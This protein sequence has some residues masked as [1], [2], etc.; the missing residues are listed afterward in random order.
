MSNTK[1]SF[2]N[3]YS[4]L[5]HPQVLAKLASIESTQFD[6][7]GLDVYSLKA[8]EL[9]KMKINA[10]HAKVYLVSGGTQANLIVISSVLRP[11]EAVISCETGHIFTHE[12]GAIEATGHKICAV[13]GENAKL[14]SKDIK[15]VLNEHQNEHMVKPKLVYLSLSTELGSVYTKNEL[16]E[17][18]ECCREN[19]LYLHIDGARLGAGINS[20]ACDLSYSDIAHFSDTFFMGGT[21][22]GILF[23][24][25]IVI[26]NEKLQEDFRY[27]IK[28]KGGLLSKGASLGLQFLALLE[29]ESS[30]ADDLYDE[31]AKKANAMAM[32]LANGIR[33]LGY[34]FFSE[35]ETNQIFPIFPCSTINLLREY[36]DFH[37]WADISEGY[38][39]IRLVVSWATSLETI[40]K[41]LSDLSHT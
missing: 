20:P 29:K 26:C 39:A 7:Y 25:A 21:K 12:T 9:I 41:F 2:K 10:P 27:T 13:K 37:D 38:K 15:N 31:L 6:G 3:D 35:P 1:I 28:Q 4:E 8:E 24:E 18:Y 34:E 16:E 22:N 32:E 23:G 17:I 30:D 19:N 14:T 36:Y 33:E 11:H 40:K 5:A